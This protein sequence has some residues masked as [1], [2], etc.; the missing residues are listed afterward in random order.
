MIIDETY[1]LTTKNYHE[2]E[3]IKKQIVFGNTLNHDMRHVSGWLHRLNGHYKKTA[4]F[5]IDA[6][7]VVYK[8]FDPKYQSDYFKDLEQNS[9]TIVILLENDGWLVKDK[10]INEFI[11]CLGHI[12]KEQ[13]NIV[14]KKWR[15]YDFWAPYSDKQLESAFELVDQLCEEFFIPKTALNNNVKNDDLNEYMG[16]L[17]KS[18]LNKIYT[19]LSPAFDFETFKTKIET[20]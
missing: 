11:S 20:I 16:V 9:K 1:L 19:D 6:A 5:T 4:A 12:Y 14:K 10:E 18:N 8:H 3:S 2:I 15:G 7:G 17:Y 13:E